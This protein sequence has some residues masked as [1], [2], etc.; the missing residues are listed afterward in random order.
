MLQKPLPALV[1]P[2]VALS[3]E[4]SLEFMLTH[5]L[6][7]K[8]PVERKIDVRI[9]SEKLWTKSP[10][11]ARVTRVR[12]LWMIEKPPLKNKGTAYYLL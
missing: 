10:W 5:W 8:Y 12:K 6:S 7:R 3:S 9:R 4:E 2:V 1:S 11:K